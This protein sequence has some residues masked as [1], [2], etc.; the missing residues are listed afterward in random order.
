MKG[1][2]EIKGSFIS[3]IARIYS[4]AKP[5]IPLI[6]LPFIWREKPI[7]PIR[8]LDPSIPFI[9]FIPVNLLSSH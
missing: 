7:L 8:F 3:F 9:P 2:K 6:R 5:F 1:A 4:P